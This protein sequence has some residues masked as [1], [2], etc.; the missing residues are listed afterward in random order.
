[1]RY[2]FKTSGTE[3]GA[4][5]C[6][7]DLGP[8]PTTSQQLNVHATHTKTSSVIPPEDGRLTPEK[9]RGLQQNEVFL[10]VKVY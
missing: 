7:T 8:Q 4:M 6:Q 2:I 5:K 1:M 9:C 3:T 10:K